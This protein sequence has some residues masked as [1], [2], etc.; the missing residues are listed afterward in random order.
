MWGDSITTLRKLDLFLS[1][2]RNDAKV[3]PHRPVLMNES[4]SSNRR[5]VKSKLLSSVSIYRRK[6]TQYSKDCGKKSEKIHTA[7]IISQNI[8]K[9]IAILYKNLLVGSTY[10]LLKFFFSINSHLQIQHTTF[11]LT[12]LSTLSHRTYL[13]SHN[14]THFSHYQVIRNYHNP[15]L[16]QRRPGT[17]PPPPDTNSTVS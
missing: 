8:A 16:F 4:V 17:P 14:S 12:Y 2:D 11:P 7:Q 3:V 1:S 10:F 9:T 13:T 6:Q 15:H 5:L